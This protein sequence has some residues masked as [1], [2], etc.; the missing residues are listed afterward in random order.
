MTGTVRERVKS[1]QWQLLKGS[2]FFGFFVGW[3][4]LK[5]VKVKGT[6]GGVVNFSSDDLWLGVA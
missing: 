5:G 1:S 2:T 3:L 4:V 6:L